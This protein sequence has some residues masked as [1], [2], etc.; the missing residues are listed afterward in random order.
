[1]QFGKKSFVKYVLCKD[2][3]TFWDLSLYTLKNGF[4][5]SKV[6][7]VDEVQDNVFPFMNFGIRFPIPTKSF[8]DFD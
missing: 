1:M 6:P 8:W 3:L 7:N 2:F 4:G 5:R